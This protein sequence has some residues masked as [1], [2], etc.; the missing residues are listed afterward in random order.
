MSY[1]FSSLPF[2]SREQAALGEAMH[3]RVVVVVAAAAV[4]VVVGAAAVAVVVVIGVV[5]I[6]V[7][8]IRTKYPPYDYGHA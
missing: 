3:L 4:P 1:I 7:F 8:A 6:R 5:D 2:S